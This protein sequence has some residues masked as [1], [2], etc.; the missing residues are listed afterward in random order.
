M[1]L[2]EKIR[3]IIVDQSGKEPEYVQIETELIDFL[4]SLDQT[5]LIMRFEEEFKL[6]IPD[7]D[8]GKIKT[9]GDIVNYLTAK[10]VTVS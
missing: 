1:T 3:N 7:E 9:V 4:D 2:E 8:A 10:G 6:E 5:E